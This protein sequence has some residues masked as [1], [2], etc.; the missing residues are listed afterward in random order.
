MAATD[1]FTGCAGNSRDMY[2]N[3]VAVVPSDTVDLVSISTALYVGV[4]GDVTVIMADLATTVLLKAMPVG[5]YRGLR[6]SRVKA[7]G[8]AATNIVALW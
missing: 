3:A 5:L 1:P 4:A 7:T 6:V 8:T 2:N